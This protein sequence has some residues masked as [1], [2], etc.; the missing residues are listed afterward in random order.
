MKTEVRLVVLKIIGKAITFE[1]F[2]WTNVY[3][4]ASPMSQTHAYNKL[5]DSNYL[6][7]L[8]QTVAN[9]ANS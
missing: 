6:E 4:W 3:T 5:F 7:N 1:L 9:I 8:N 2:Y